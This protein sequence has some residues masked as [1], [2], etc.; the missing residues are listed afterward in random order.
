MVVAT[1]DHF[2]VIKGVKHTARRLLYNIIL[3]VDISR[4]MEEQEQ[5]DDGDDDE[6][7]S[8]V[9]YTIII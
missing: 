7:T 9:C 3:W 1:T 6:R 2:G 5:N 4:R 8:P